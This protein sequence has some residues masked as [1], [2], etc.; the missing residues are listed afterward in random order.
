MG[1]FDR[2]ELLQSM[3][4]SQQNPLRTIGFSSQL[5]RLH[6]DDDQ[7]WE[8]AKKTAQRLVVILHPDHQDADEQS[9]DIEIR[10]AFESLKDKDIFLRALEDL[11]KDYNE[12]RSVENERKRSVDYSQNQI[13]EAKLREQNAVRKQEELRGSLQQL[14]RQLVEKTGIEMVKIRNPKDQSRKPLEQV[15]MLRQVGK[16]IAIRVSVEVWDGTL[17][18]PEVLTQI[19]TKYKSDRQRV[20]RQIEKHNLT[21]VAKGKKKVSLNEE[22]LAGYIG[23]AQQGIVKGGFASRSFLEM[24]EEVSTDPIPTLFWDLLSAVDKYGVAR[25][26]QHKLK[27]PSPEISLRASGF[28]PEVFS[29]AYRAVFTQI[30]DYLKPQLNRISVVYI[31]PEVIDMTY[32]TL[33]QAMVMGSVFIGEQPISIKMVPGSFDL[34]AYPED[35]KRP[36]LCEGALIA[37]T[38]P[39]EI[40]V[41]GVT[42][43]E[44]ADKLPSLFAKNLA[45]KRMISNYV[46][47]EFL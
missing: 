34:G 11:K 43:R 31:H 32:G 12:G 44:R 16:V 24:V 29:A 27:F 23:L 17:A 20:V 4:G 13:K 47:L 37:T 36:Y 8:F 6:L 33:D 38:A 26:N 14:H 18:K 45:S 15:R 25:G 41:T 19:L 46:L 21:R 39:T 22:N 40:G 9:A 42:A 3:T 7:L 28:E 35:L 2:T 10:S 30:V 1:V 5:L